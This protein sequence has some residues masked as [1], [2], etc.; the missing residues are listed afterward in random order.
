MRQAPKPGTYA[1]EAPWWQD[2]QQGHAS[3]TVGAEDAPQKVAAVLWVPD[4]EQTHGWREYYVYR[5]EP[6]PG[7][8]PFGFGKGG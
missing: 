5:D 3:S 7:A 2:L 1:L 6:K 8:R 4:I